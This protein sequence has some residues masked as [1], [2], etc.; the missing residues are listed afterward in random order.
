MDDHEEKTYTANN[1]TITT[2]SSPSSR[3]SA[4]NDERVKS[5]FRKMSLFSLSESLADH[6][7]PRTVL[8]IQQAI[9]LIGLILLM[10]VVLQIP[11]IL[12]YANP[13]SSLS[14]GTSIISDFNLDTC[15]VS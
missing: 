1:E 12:Y 4:V 9:V 6:V 15:S 5:V 2:S 3:P 11:T 7:N 8:T 10:I 14:A 13:P